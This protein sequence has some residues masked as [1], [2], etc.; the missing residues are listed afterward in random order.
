EGLRVVDLCQILAGPSSARMLGEFGADITKV[1]APQRPVSAHAIVNRGKNSVLLDI[2]SEA[3]KEVL[4]RLIDEADVFVQN[5]PKGTAERY[6][7]G[8]EHLK[9]RRPG[10]VYVSVSC[11]GYAGPWGHR[12][13]YETQGQAT[14]G[15]M[16]RVGG[17]YPPGILGPYNVLD[18]G[19]GVM[20]AFA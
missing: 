19:T 20:A 2:E 3:G 12:R 8:Y 5:F 14:S 16:P 6:G 4:W 7:L 9:A 11:Y 13:G 18:Y 1:N 15:I 10:I 17:E